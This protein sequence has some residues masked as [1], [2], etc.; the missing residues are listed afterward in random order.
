MMKKLAVRCVQYKE[1]LVLNTHYRR[2]EWCVPNTSDRS[3]M[4]MCV[5]RL[6]TG[7][8]ELHGGGICQQHDMKM[9]PTTSHVSATICSQR[10]AAS[11]GAENCVIFLMLD[12]VEKLMS[13]LFVCFGGG[14]CCCCFISCGVFFFS[15]IFIFSQFRSSLFL[16]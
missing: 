9:L 5:L 2:V 8:S 1:E 10:F 12:L 13:W 16:F 6:C 7:V 14:L 11:R 15:W 4:R 3:A